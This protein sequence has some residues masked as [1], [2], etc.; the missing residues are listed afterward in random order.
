MRWQDLSEQSDDY[1]GSCPGSP[2]SLHLGVGL[3]PVAAQPGKHQPRRANSCTLKHRWLKL[4]SDR[5]S[6][7]KVC[8]KRGSNPRP[9]AYKAVALPAE[10]FR[11]CTDSLLR[12]IESRHIS[13]KADDRDRLLRGQAKHLHLRKKDFPCAVFG[14]KHSLNLRASANDHRVYG[15]TTRNWCRADSAQLHANQNPFCGP[16]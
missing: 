2:A 6:G 14:L 13:K 7:G 4:Q 15:P 8:R 5:A 16:P 11:R 9:T 12:P 3:R 10:L 1:R